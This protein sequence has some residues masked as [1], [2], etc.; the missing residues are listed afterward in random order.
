MIRVKETQHIPLVLVGNK[1]DMD[2]NRKVQTAEGE[3]L[4]AKWNNS[5]FFETSSKDGLNVEKCFHEVVRL[6]RK[7]PATEQKRDEKRA[8]WK[9]C[10]IL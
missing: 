4:A 10:V 5:P 8:W 7:M 3:A 9:N 6:I 1:C 2:S